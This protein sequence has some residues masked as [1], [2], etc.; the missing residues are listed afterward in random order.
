LGTYAAHRARLLSLTWGA[1]DLPAAL[2]ASANRGEDGGYS[3]I[4]RLARSLCLAGAAAAGVGAIET[5]FP[6]FRD[7][8]GLER[9]AERG[10][11]EGFTGMMA[12]HPDQV[13]VINRAFTPSE[14]ELA[15]ARSVVALFESRPGAG[16]LSLDGRMLD[17]PHF[18]QA[19]RLLERAFAAVGRPGDAMAPSASAHRG[20]DPPAIN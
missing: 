11:I 4:C 6:A 3:D 19:R 8:A 2:G 17:R 10:R 14:T 15:W 5:V 12:I 7:L 18:E 13:A 9:Y 1:E 20:D 16:A